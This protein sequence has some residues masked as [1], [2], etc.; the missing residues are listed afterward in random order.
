MVQ[1]AS[2]IDKHINMLF[3]DNTFFDKGCDGFLDKQYAVDATLRIIRALPLSA[4][5]IL[6][7]DL[8]GKER[9]CMEVAIALGERV[10]L[11]PD[12]LA[13]ISLLGDEALVSCGVFTSDPAMVRD[14]PCCHVSALSMLTA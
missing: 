6:S 2:L 1:H 14:D 5:V 11:H 7:L 4:T 3:I 12:K 9:Y 10:I 13:T 8:L